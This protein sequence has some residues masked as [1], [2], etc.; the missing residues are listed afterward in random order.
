MIVLVSDHCLSIY[1]IDTMIIRHNLNEIG[2]A[3][4]GH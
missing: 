3:T 1:F 4:L 2:M